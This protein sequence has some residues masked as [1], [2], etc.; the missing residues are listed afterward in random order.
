MAGIQD[1]Q[2]K[3]LSTLGQPL[4]GDVMPV[5]TGSAVGQLQDAFAKGLITPLDIQQRMTQLGIS[6]SQSQV[7][8]QKARLGEQQL[9]ESLDPEAVA[10]R[11]AQLKLEKEKAIAGSETLLSKDFVSAYMRYNLPL[12]KE[13]GSYDYTGMAEVGQKYA[14]MERIATYAEKGLTGKP[15]S[16]LDSKGRT[17]TRVYNEFGEDITTVPDKVN[18]VVRDYQNMLRKARS[19]LLQNDN[20]PS[21]AEGKTPSGI[22][23]SPKHVEA[24]PIVVE[25]PKT[26]ESWKAE[27]PPAPV[28][29]ADPSQV[30]GWLFK[31]KVLPEA[32][33][34][35]LT[36]SEALETYGS[37]KEH[38][39]LC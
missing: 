38:Y 26:W 31:S 9:K 5:V 10:A 3:S 23:V 21:V 14:D 6:K 33:A 29:E 35:K 19:F 37:L 15:V 34:I 20:E 24:G 28:N 12:K 39:F 1:V 13:D 36:D 8:A 18:P 32:A 7:E 25:P 22:E 27:L 11:A 2:P 17:V 16:S 30:R 4:V